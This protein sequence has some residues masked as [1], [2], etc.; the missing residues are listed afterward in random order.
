MMAGQPDWNGCPWFG[1]AVTGL[2]ALL[3]VLDNEN[4]S[5]VIE[6]RVLCPNDLGFYTML[7][8]HRG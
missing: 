3:L 8:I 1:A 5:R 4:P 7:L 2:L 6:A